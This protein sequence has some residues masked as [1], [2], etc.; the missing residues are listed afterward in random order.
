LAQ[1]AS[2]CD[3]TQNPDR[4][5]AIKVYFTVHILHQW[6]GNNDNL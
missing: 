5:W 6:W 1:Q 3:I 2:I 4:I